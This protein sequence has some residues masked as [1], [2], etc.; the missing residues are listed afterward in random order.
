MDS[1][2]FKENKRIQVKLYEGALKLTIDAG[3]YQK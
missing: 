1:S 2:A 3:T